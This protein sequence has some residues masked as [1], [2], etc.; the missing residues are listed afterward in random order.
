[1]QPMSAEPTTF[2]C[3]QCGNCCRWPGEVRVSPEEIRA[4]AGRLGL[5][6]EAFIARHPQVT[7]DRQ[8]L[9]LVE[10]AGGACRFLTPENRCAIQSAKPRQCREFPHQWRAPE[11]EHLCAGLREPHSGKEPA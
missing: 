10:D 2:A 8:G 9:T 11:H 1:M 6:E 5:T 4:A 3:R 7:R